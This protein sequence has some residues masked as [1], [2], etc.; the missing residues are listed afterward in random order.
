MTLPSWFTA[1]R[2]AWRRYTLR[3]AALREFRG[4]SD[5]MLNDIGITRDMIEDYVYGKLPRPVA[6]SSRLAQGPH[7]VVNNKRVGRVG[8]ATGATPACCAEAA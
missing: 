6:P 1:L 7:L 4:F 8:T 2:D 3:A 5:A